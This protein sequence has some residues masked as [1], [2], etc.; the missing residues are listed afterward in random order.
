MCSLSVPERGAPT[1]RPCF[2]NPVSTTERRVKA[3]AQK[4]GRLLLPQHCGQIRVERPETE[5][6]GSA[7]HGVFPPPQW[8]SHRPPRKEVQA[9]CWESRPRGAGGWAAPRPRPR[10]GSLRTPLPTYAD[11]SRG[12]CSDCTGSPAPRGSCGCRSRGG[13]LGRRG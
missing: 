10:R 8:Q 2:V 9:D 4:L 1:G 12:G 5:V 3:I 11:A 7:I 13:A 6:A